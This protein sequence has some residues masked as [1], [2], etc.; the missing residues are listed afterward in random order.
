MIELAALTE[1]VVTNLSAA[2]ALATTPILVGDGIAPKAGGYLAGQP[3]SSEF[4]PYATVV[5]LE[6]RVRA[7]SPSAMGPDDYDWDVPYKIAAYGATRRQADWVMAGARAASEAVLL[8]AV[9]GAVSFHQVFGVD[10]RS[11]G[12]PNRDD[13]VTPPLWGITDVVVLACTRR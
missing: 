1:L 13:A 5:Q 8:K 12:G 10:Y 2:L 4:T 11:L 6:A 9:F 7:P 3:D